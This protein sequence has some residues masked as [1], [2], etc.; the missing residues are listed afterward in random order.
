MPTFAGTPVTIKGKTKQKGDEAPTFTVLDRDF[1]KRR[2]E[3]FDNEYIVIS[4]VPSIDTSVCDYQTK[5]FNSKLESFDNV[6]VLTIS[7]DLPFAQKRWCANEGMES[8]V[9]LSDYKDLDF[10]MKYGTL[11]DEYR[12]QARSVFVLDRERRIIH[13]EYVDEV[14]DHPDYD[15]V[16]QLL[17]S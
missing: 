13:L 1:Q 12:L 3:D 11:I 9:T 2:L 16:V 15:K 5:A 4:V 17:E 10:A 14:G 7:N 6:T 8:I